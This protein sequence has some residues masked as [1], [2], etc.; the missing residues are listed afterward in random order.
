M[1]D[2][3]STIAL[4]STLQPAPTTAAE[5]ETLEAKLRGKFDIVSAKYTAGGHTVDLLRPRSVDDLINEEE[6]KL[7]GRLPYWADV[8][9]AA[10]GLAGR[11]AQENGQGKR[12]LELGC[13]IGYIACLASKIGFEVTATDYYL[14]TIDFTRLNAY[15]NDLAIPDCRM[16]DWRDYPSD[17]NNFDLIVASDVLYE[18]PYCELVAA[19][20]SKS[21]SP[22]GLALVSDPNRT[23]AEGFPEACERHGLRLIKTS[24]MPAEMEDRCQ[25]INV[26]E[27]RHA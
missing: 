17:L 12:M 21:L 10:I 15:R 14:P 3:S 2:S 26:Y 4:D 7:D 1:T 11:I 19:C 22:E 8:W 24:R 27:L 25:M 23:L 18:K 5:W 9:P 16:V 20:I 13:A 6:F